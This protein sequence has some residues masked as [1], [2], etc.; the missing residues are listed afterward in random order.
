MTP[1]SLSVDAS[2][3]SVWQLYSGG[4]VRSCPLRSQVARPAP[5]VSRELTLRRHRAREHPSIPLSTHPTPTLAPTPHPC[6]HPPHPPRAGDGQVQHVHQRRLP[7]PRRDGHRV[8]HRRLGPGLLDRE[9]LVGR[10]LGAWRRGARC[11]GCGWR[12]S[13]CQRMTPGFNPVSARHTRHAAATP[14]PSRAP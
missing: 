7:G 14:K 6:P 9:E 3:D 11:S 2:D 1:L 4:V 12:G 13:C 5:F 10:R 8:R